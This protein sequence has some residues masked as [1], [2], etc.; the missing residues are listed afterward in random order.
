MNDDKILVD[1]SVWID[2]FKGQNDYIVNLMDAIFAK[3]NIYTIRA[4]VR[5]KYFKDILK[6]CKK[7]EKIQ[8]KQKNMI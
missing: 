3:S 1:T 2:Y 6:Y 4:K 5:I 7:Y 8:N